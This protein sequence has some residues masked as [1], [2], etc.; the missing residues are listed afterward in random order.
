MVEGKVDFKEMSS[1]SMSFRES[2]WVIRVL[3]VVTIRCCSA[4][5]GRGINIEHIAPINKL[6]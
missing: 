3:T 2:I 1:S 5:G 6:A 4:R